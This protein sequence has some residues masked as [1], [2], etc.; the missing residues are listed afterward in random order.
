[1]VSKP[2]PQAR[3]PAPTNTAREAVEVYWPQ[4][5]LGEEEFCR[6]ARILTYGYDS[7]VTR[8][9]RSVNQNGLF[10]H[11]RDLLYAVQRERSLRRPV[12]F[13]A[14]SLGGLLLKEVSAIR[15]LRGQYHRTSSSASDLNVADAD[16]RATVDASAVCRLG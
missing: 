8:G 16:L 15:A 10:A 12:I 3:P 1:V 14:H 7:R 11:A 9:Y 2:Q 6:Q 13:V 4:D 5:L